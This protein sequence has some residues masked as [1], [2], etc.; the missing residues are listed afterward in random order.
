MQALLLAV[1]NARKAGAESVRSIL[2]AVHKIDNCDATECMICSIAQC[3]HSEPLHFHHDGCPACEGPY[4][5]NPKEIQD[6]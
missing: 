6:A 1:E 4:G 2:Q 5:M 3:P